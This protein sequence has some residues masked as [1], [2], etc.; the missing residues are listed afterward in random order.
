MFGCAEIAEFCR[1]LEPTAEETAAR[2]AAMERVSA[3]VTAIWPTA[4]VQVRAPAQHLG[5]STYA[6]AG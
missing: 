1:F 6:A 2:A 3:V 5:S 4:N